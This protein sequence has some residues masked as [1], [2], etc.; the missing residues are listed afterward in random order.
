MPPVTKF[1]LALKAF[2]EA[3]PLKERKVSRSLR[4]AVNNAKL[5]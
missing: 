5:K 4:E 2:L 1:E 3:P